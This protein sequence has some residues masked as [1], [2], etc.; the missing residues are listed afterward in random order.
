M[1]LV[2]AQ[3]HNGV[4]YMGADTQVSQKVT[5]R[6]ELSESEYKIGKLPYGIL[7][8][9]AGAARAIKCLVSHYEWFEALGE[10]KLSKKFLVTEI[11]PKLYSKFKEMGWLEE[12][13]HSPISPISCLFAQGDRLFY[14]DDDF[15]V[16]VAPSY[17]AVGCGMNAALVVHKQNKNTLTVREELLTSLRLSSEYDK[18]VGAP[19]VFI[20]TENLKFEVVEE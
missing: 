20:D 19:F 17:G 4:V 9:G 8:G 2:I 18:G 6:H 1:S 13:K 3:V 5:K 14:M 7:I 12:G 16:K 15:T 10:E 11:V